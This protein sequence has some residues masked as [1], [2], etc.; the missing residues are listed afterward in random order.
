[1]EALANNVILEDISVECRGCRLKR[2]ESSVR[3]RSSVKNTAMLSEWFLWGIFSESSAAVHMDH[4]GKLGLFKI[5]SESSVAAGDIRCYG[6]E[7]AA[8]V[9]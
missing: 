1:M 6:L 4:T 7:Y 8:T 9:Q 2:R 3:W 5:V